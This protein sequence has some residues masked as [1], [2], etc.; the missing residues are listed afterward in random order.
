MASRK[1]LPPANR[2]ITDAYH[3][4]KRREPGLTQGEFA[5]RTFPAMP[6]QSG[7]RSVWDSRKGSRQLTRIMRGEDRQLAE[8]LVSASYD[9][10][11]ANVE[12]TDQS[13]VPI[14]FANVLLP[15]GTSSFDSYKLAHSR[16]GKQLARRMARG[17]LAASAP[18]LVQ[19]SREG[20]PRVSA[21]RPV[22]MND[23]P[24]YVGEI[25]AL[26]PE[27]TESVKTSRTR[28][29]ISSA[30]ERAADP[31]VDMFVDFLLGAL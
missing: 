14:G 20:T 15:P 7:K 28:Q 5:R 2:L 13:G 3:D 16:S 21:V 12:F 11:V 17:R 22:K 26:D 10:R 23:D 30:V 4:A 18:R 29:R 31:S 27:P 8:R 25:S 9:L 19:G 1:R 6:D 24:R